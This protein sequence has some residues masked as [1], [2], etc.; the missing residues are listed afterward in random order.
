MISPTKINAIAAKYE[1]EN[2]AFRQYLKEHADSDKLDA[3]FLKL[4]NELFANHDCCQC[5]NCC[6]AYA[7]VLDDNDIEVISQHLGQSKGAFISE[8]LEKSD[9]DESY[10]KMNKQPCAFL[11][12]DGKCSIN[13]VKPAECKGFPFTDHP[14]RLESMLGVISFAEEC[15]V[16]FEILERLKKICRFKYRR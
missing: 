7:V 3:Q 5:N 16:V 9:Y 15:P 13:E 6:R 8:Y 11:Q 14:D 2:I 1:D 4:H 12:A 10:Y